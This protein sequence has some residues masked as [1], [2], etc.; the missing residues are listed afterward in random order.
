[1][2]KLLVPIGIL[3]ALLLASCTTLDQKLVFKGVDPSL[4][5]S[6]SASLFVNGA[7]VGEGEYKTLAPISVTK[8][9]V[10][11]LK[12]KE[13]V[14]DISPDLKSAVAQQGG[15][16]VAK[17]K[18]SIDG[19]SSPD[20]AWV[21]IERYLGAYTMVFSGCFLAMSLSPNPGVSAPY[22]SKIPLAFGSV[23]AGGAALFG[24]SF[25][26]ESLGHATYSIG[27]NGVAVKIAK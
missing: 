12:T 18:I 15:D 25:L 17:L 8:E 26:H 6:A 7:A 16:A 27:L 9:V 11:P 3:V 19:F 13:S 10:V 5:T 23:C 2:K 21:G 22:D 1:M 24:L 20:Y 14:V 4:P